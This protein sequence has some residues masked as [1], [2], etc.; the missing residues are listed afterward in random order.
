MSTGSMTFNTASNV[1]IRGTVLGYCLPM[2]DTTQVL[3]AGLL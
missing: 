2:Y 1:Y 3:L